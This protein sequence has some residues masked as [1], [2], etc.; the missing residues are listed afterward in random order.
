MRKF[1]GRF[2][3]DGLPCADADENTET[4]ELTLTD[5]VTGALLRLYYTVF[6][7]SDVISRYFVLENHGKADLRIEKAMPLAL[8]IDG[9][10]RDM[11]S[12]YGEWAHERHIQ[13]QPLMRGNQ[14]IFSRRG[15]SSHHFSP[16]MMV[17]DK[18]ATEERGEAY[19]FNFVWS[20][21]WLGEVETDQTHNTRVLLGLGDECF[22]YL[23]KSGESFASPEA[24]MTY[25]AGGIGRASRNMHRFVRA[26]ILPRDKFPLRPVV[27]NSWEAFF[28]NIDAE[29]MESFGAEAAKCGIDM[30]V[31][32]DGWFGKRVNDKAGL[33]DW[34]ANADRFPDGL[35]PFVRRVKKNGI[36]FG[37]WYE[38]EMISRDSNLYRAH[39][40]W[41]IHVPG[42]EK[43]IA[44]H[45]YVLDY[46]RQDVRDYIFGEM[47][48]VLSTCEID[49]LKWDFNRNLTEVGSAALPADKQKV[50]CIIC[51]ESSEKQTLC[52]NHA[53]SSICPICFSW[54]KTG[55]NFF[56]PKRFEK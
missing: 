20:G 9:D 32:D 14:R 22:N 34:Y 6:P 5:E 25:S 7:E 29:R 49:Y 55:L 41:C 8:D 3:P 54:A 18:K 31:M 27:L 30:V 10:E 45:Q 21:S 50:L 15:S 23:L 40:D 52:F 16:F 56:I 36:K 24:V 35:A 44:R 51:T 13:R 26:H 2:S 11:I 39:P 53:F 28:F 17:T 38:P 47:K 42:R 48:K 43:S 19:A 12:F 46:S 4:L 37:I 1:K 33:G